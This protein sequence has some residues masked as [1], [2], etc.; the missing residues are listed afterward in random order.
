MFQNRHWPEGFEFAACAA[1]NGGTREDDAMVALLARMSPN[2]LGNRDGRLDQIVNFLFRRFPGLFEKM[3]PTAIEARRMNK[4]F[5]IQPTQGK[6]HQEMGVVRVTGEMNDAVCTFA[7]KL[8]KAIYYK[9][10]GKIFP[11][12][13]SVVLHWATNADVFR[14]GSYPVF[15]ILAKLTGNAPPI[16]RSRKSL[17]D[18]FEYKVSFDDDH[19]MIVQATFSQ[20]FALSIFT[21][22]QPGRLEDII[23]KI[24]KEAG[25]PS[26]FTVLQSPDA[27]SLKSL[28]AP[29]REWPI[30]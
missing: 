3:R 4:E 28:S 30:S 9:E 24:A 7:N 11:A 8:A 25:Y 13:G 27:E 18:Q 2:D 21:S 14:H 20:S 23:R 1:C 29:F 17:R 22:T 26:P 16:E 19:L 12:D 15:E 6:T 10:T 5:G